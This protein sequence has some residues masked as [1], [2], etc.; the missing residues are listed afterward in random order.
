MKKSDL[1]YEDGSPIYKNETLKEVDEDLNGFV[2]TYLGEKYKVVGVGRISECPSD[3]MIYG[4]DRNLYTIESFRGFNGTRLYVKKAEPL[5][6][7][8][9]VEEIVLRRKTITAEDIYQDKTIANLQVGDKYKYD[10]DLYKVV[11]FRAPGVKESYIYSQSGYVNKRGYVGLDQSN[12]RIIVE[13]L[14][15]KKKKYVF[16]EDSN[17]PYVMTP[18]GTFVN[19]TC[20]QGIK[21]KMEV[22]EE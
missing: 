1:K 13:R 18:D 4:S 6:H 10:G 11:A 15:K 7:T 12:P 9:S 20:A 17:G 19:V 16:T 3:A 5:E 21:Y 22:V 2:Y 14:A 8:Y